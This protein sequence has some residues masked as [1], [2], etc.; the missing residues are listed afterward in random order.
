MIDAILPI[1]SNMMTKFTS[2]T[3]PNL[4]FIILMTKK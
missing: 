3:L 4:S 2:I 1:V